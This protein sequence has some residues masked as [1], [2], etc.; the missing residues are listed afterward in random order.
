MGLLEKIGIRPLDSVES[1]LRNCGAP[2]V[3][4]WR[5]L[6]GLEV[7]HF[8]ALH[9]ADADEIPI[10]RI[11]INRRPQS[12]NII[13]SVY[14]DSTGTLVKNSVWVIPGCGAGSKES[15][16]NVAGEPGESLKLDGA[17]SA[18]GTVMLDMEH[19]DVE[20][21]THSLAVIKG[22]KTKCSCCSQSFPAA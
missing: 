21:A 3:A 12:I 14:D 13:R 11:R 8:L 20:Q 18:S 9:D 19:D 4:C 2:D 6:N 5:P 1:V 10:R 16:A 17:G 15:V 7:A 22:R